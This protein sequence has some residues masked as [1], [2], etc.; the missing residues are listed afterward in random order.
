MISGDQALSFS[1]K[2]LQTLR[3]YVNAGG[4]I[5]GNAD[6]GSDAFVKSFQ[7]LGGQLFPQYEFRQLPDDHLLFNNQYQRSSWRE[8][9]EIL[10][11][12][13]GARE[14]MLLFPKGDPARALMIGDSRTDIDTAKAAGIPVVAVD[15]GYTDRHVREFEPSAIISHYDSLTLAMAERLIAA[16]NG[17]AHA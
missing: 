8:T 5:V 6:C 17:R 1:E 2:Q 14:L 16:T 9:P 11:L 15:F 4:L 13:N 12:S 3:A 7:S 10:G